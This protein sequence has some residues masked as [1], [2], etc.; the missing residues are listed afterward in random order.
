[1][2]ITT[3]ELKELDELFKEMYMYSFHRPQIQVTKKYKTLSG[4]HDKIIEELDK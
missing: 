1:M 4:F 2:K 3:N